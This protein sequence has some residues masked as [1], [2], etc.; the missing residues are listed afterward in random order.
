MVGIV[1]KNTKA[2]IKE[3]KQQ[4]HYNEW[5]FVYDPT[6]DLLGSAGITGGG[7]NLNGP[8]GTGTT[9]TP[10]SGFPGTSTPGSPT[11]PTSPVSNPPTP[12]PSPTP[13]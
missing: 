3:Y 10:T 8:G 13:Q 2:S 9:G 6:E 4:K 7:T 12:S 11:S 5:E 1:S